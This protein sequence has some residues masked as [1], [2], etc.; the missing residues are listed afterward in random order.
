MRSIVFTASLFLFA[1]LSLRLKR[2]YQRKAL[3]TVQAAKDINAARVH[4]WPLGYVHPAPKGP[5]P[6][7]APVRLTQSPPR[8][9]LLLGWIGNPDN[10]LEYR[11]LP[12]WLPKLQL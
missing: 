2:Y 6:M 3:N 8:P 9:D 10:P 5:E 7:I 11:L 1:L 12:S 4:P